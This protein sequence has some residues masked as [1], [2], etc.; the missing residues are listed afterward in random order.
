M[1]Y[2]LELKISIIACPF[3]GSFREVFG[4]F[5]AIFIKFPPPLD[6]RGDETSIYI[7][8]CSMY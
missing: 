4:W 5:K 8:C 7:I 1:V 3:L 6:S 2:C